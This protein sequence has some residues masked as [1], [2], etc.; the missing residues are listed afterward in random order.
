MIGDEIGKNVGICA[1]LEVDD[2][3][4][5]GFVQGCRVSANWSD[6][7]RLVTNHTLP[8][9]QQKRYAEPALVVDMCDCCAESNAAGVIRHVFFVFECRL[10]AVFGS[11]V[12]ANYGIVV[13]DGRYPFEDSRLAGR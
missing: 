1:V 7:W 10:L 5:F 2:D 13:V 3:F 12:L 6:R 9:F 8:G 4:G 11:A